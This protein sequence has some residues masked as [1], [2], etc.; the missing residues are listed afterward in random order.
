MSRVNDMEFIVIKSSNQSI[1]LLREFIFVGLCVS[2]GC[3][4]VLFCGDF[5]L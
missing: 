3:V 2:V 1:T 4:Y 5:D